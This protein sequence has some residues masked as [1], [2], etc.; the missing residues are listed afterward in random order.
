MN[1]G[2]QRWANTKRQRDLMWWRSRK[3]VLQGEAEWIS[4]DDAL[5]P[6]SA[7]PCWIA[8]DLLGVSRPRIKQLLDAKILKR[9]DCDSGRRVGYYLGTMAGVSELSVWRRLGI[10]EKLP[11][12][13]PRSKA[14]WFSDSAESNERCER[15]RLRQEQK[16]RAAGIKP[17][18]QKPRYR[19][20][21]DS[22][23][24]EMQEHNRKTRTG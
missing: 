10:T 3:A 7:M 14:D 9:A 5:E 18:F 23:R 20:E 11:P 24:A 6:A 1:T 2:R 15:D 21:T 22:I 16:R 8:A 17:R 19:N 13:K 12:E 4:S